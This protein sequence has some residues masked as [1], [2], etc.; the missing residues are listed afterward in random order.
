MYGITKTH[1]RGVLSV[2]DFVRGGFCPRGILSAEILS[3]IPK[4]AF[5][6][7]CTLCDHI[8]KSVPAGSGAPNI[9]LSDEVYSER[10]RDYFKRPHDYFY[11][12]SDD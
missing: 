10:P 3:G 12:E 1:R 8:E 2:G 6:R 9:F 11:S 5:P 7:M 4:K